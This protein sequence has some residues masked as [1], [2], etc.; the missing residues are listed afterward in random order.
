MTGLY[1]NP[2]PGAK[3]C[4]C[5]KRDQFTR[6]VRNTGSATR[7]QSWAWCLYKDCGRVTPIYC[8]GRTA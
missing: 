7:M 1:Q 6:T 5:C 4:P 2:G 8:W 3:Y